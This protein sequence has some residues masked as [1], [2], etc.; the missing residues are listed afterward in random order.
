MR[1]ISLTAAIEVQRRG[2][3]RLSLKWVKDTDGTV[4]WGWAYVGLAGE[5]YLGRTK[6][7]VLQFATQ[8]ICRF[9]LSTDHDGVH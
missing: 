3:D 8:A 7:E 2:F 9:L 1:E 5:E 6:S 4:L